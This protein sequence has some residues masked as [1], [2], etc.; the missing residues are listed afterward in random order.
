MSIIS[1]PSTAS[2]FAADMAALEAEYHVRQQES[3]AQ[4][5]I[6]MQRLQAEDGCRCCWCEDLT[7]GIT[8]FGQHVNVCPACLERF[9]ELQ[10]WV[11]PTPP[12]PAIRIP[13]FIQLNVAA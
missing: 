7:G 12:R 4:Q 11:R 2:Q 3:D 9:I 13:K 6:E 1:T 10:G 8:I 5:E